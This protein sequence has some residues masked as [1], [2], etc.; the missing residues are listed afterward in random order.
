ME[1]ST[2][3][4]IGPS[5]EHLHELLLIAVSNF[6]LAAARFELDL[7]RHAEDVNRHLPNETKPPRP[8]TP[9][10]AP[11]A[12]RIGIAA[13]HAQRIGIADGMSSAS[14]SPTACLVHR[15][16]RRHV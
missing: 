12:Q 2:E 5:I 13:P 16:R 7:G 11:H 6:D 8:S 15:H 1:H 14:A 4:S 3:D 10:A 9:I